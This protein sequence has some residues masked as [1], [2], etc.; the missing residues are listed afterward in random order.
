M[1]NAPVPAGPGLPVALRGVFFLIGALLI[2]LGLIAIVCSFVAGLAAVVLWGCLLLVSGVIH[3]I[4][5][6]QARG[7]SGAFLHLLMA[8]LGVVIGIFCLNHPAEAL[9]ALTELIA[10]FLVVG[11]LFRI[12]GG[13]LMHPSG[14][15]W[16]VLSGVVGLLLGLMVWKQL[17]FSAEW[18][19]GTFVGIDLMFQGF[20]A[21]SMAV[22]ARNT[23]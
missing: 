7:W 19:V 6:F 14:W 23:A 22:S 9:V 2:L 5:V 12:F 18:L 15:L 10:I 17:P 20:S 3:G 16:T 4:A 11:G 1:S 21:V 13:L 8:V